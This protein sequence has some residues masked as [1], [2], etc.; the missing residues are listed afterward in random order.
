MA[1]ALGMGLPFIAFAAGLG[2]LTRAIAVIR[3]HGGWVT[4]LG[5]L[6]LVAVGIALV[7]GSWTEFVNWLRATVGPGQIGI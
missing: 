4:R 6:L 2:W 3:R 1:Y 7:T 5:G